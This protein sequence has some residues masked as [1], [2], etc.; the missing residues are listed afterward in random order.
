MSNPEIEI[1]PE[2]VA[3]GVKAFGAYDNAEWEA[4]TVDQEAFIRFILEHALAARK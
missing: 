2:M 3:A 1:T 4:Y